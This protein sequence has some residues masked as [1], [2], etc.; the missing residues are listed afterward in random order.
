[1]VTWYSKTVT[2]NMVGHKVPHWLCSSQLKQTHCSNMTFCFWVCRTAHSSTRRTDDKSREMS[3]TCWAYTTTEVACAEADSRCK[4]EIMESWVCL[5]LCA[6]RHVWVMTERER[7][8]GWKRQRRRTSVVRRASVWQSQS[9]WQSDCQ[10][11]RWT[12]NKPGAEQLSARVT[13]IYCL[14]SGKQSSPTL[15]SS[16]LMHSSTSD[17]KY[18]CLRFCG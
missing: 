15:V 2:V 7:Q 16:A 14:C 10:K 6:Q 17:L 5:C 4:P 3:G 12:W 8:R 1:M 18:I 9:R 13:Q 11:L